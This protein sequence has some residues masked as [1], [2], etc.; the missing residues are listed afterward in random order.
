MTFF[1]PF[2]LLWLATIPVLLWLWRLAAAQRTVRIPS[3]VPFEHLMQRLARR[4][5]Q[6]VV[7]ALFWLQA[8]AIVLLAAALA[9]PALWQ[10]RARTVLVVLDTSASMGAV[11]RGSTLWARGTRQLLARLR[12]TRGDRVLFMTTAP[13]RAL[14]PEPLRDPAQIARL[15]GDAKVSDLA[16]TLGT[17]AHIGRALLGGVVDRTLVVTDEPPPQPPPEGVEFLSV[18]TPLSNVALVGLDTQGGFCAE[19]PARLVASVQNFSRQPARVEV[20]AAQRGRALAQHE[21][22][23]A[24]GE[25]AN[26]VLA[27]P[28]GTEGW[29]EVALRTPDDALAADNRAWV[30]VH[31]TVALPVVVRSEREAFNDLMSRWLSACQGLTWTRQ[32]PADAAGPYLLVTDGSA[33]PSEIEGRGS[34]ATELAAAA[35]LQWLDGRPARGPRPSSFEGTRAEGRGGPV[36][37]HWLVD[38]GHPVGSYLGGI[39][40]VAASLE[41]GLPA[42]VSGE[43]VV[44]SVR[45]GQKVP[46]VV[47]GEQQGHRRVAILVD[48]VDSPEAMPLV[49]LF[50]NS[51]QWLMKRA[52]VGRT[53]EPLW[54]ALPAGPVAVERPDGRTDQL[55]HPGGTFHYEE[56]TRAGLYRVAQGRTERRWGVNFL[57][58]VESNLLERPSTWQPADSND[59]APISA[60]RAPRP[61]TDAL[62]RLLLVLVLVEWWLYSRRRSS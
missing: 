3:L 17:A 36:L 11:Q 28:E 27:V 21:A 44:W 29:L 51:L 1:S 26:V 9:R 49:V 25:R 32:G 48:P 18:G 47:A 60:P 31:R 41:T 15:V 20:T 43:P 54:G 59:T 4:R 39:E 53:G 8:A 24:A 57:D 35:T 42:G 2:Q 19:E 30:P 14:S 33:R 38:S 13:V 62:T 58:P 16:G 7:N 23:L 46:V 40:V 45:N 55:A 34:P 12:A 37:A 22:T 61:L 5:R 10:R 56:T 50:F 52:D 6:L